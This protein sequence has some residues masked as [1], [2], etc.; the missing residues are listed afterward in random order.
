MYGSDHSFYRSLKLFEVG[1]QITTG[2]R[3]QGK[4]G[5]QKVMVFVFVSSAGDIR[6]RMEI[7]GR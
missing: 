2:D 5:D 4:P 1:M 6:V 7:A 3:S